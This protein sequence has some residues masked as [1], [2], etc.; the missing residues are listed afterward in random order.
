M[1]SPTF[2]S[3]RE[4]DIPDFRRIASDAWAPIF[5][6]F[7]EAMGDELWAAQREGDPR[8]AKADQ[9]ESQFR[10]APDRFF[11]AEIDG[12]VIGFCTFRLSET[13]LGEIGNNAIDPA[14]QGRGLGTAMHAECL[15]RLREAG[16]THAKVT[17]GD[18]D[19]HAAARHAYEKLGFRPLRVHLDYFMEL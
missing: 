17:T 19:G 3:A 11:V 9:V 6:G 7:R 15:R 5:D 12:K 4:T 10:N 16:M 13:G 18:D 2:R 1:T 14:C 8:E